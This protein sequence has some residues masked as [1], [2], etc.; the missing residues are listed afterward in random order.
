M[1]RFIKE[2]G[3]A[4][5]L[6]AAILLW[7]KTYAAYV[8]E[9]NLGITNTVQQI[10]LFVNPISSS[11]FFL[12]LGLLFKKKIQQTAII[13]I[14][15]LMSFLL[16]ANVVYYRFFSDF[17]TLPTI[18]QAK[19][20]GGQLGDSIFSLMHPLDVLYFIDTFILIGLAVFYNRP[21]ETTT[22]RPFKI[23][24]GTSIL[25]F[26]VN[27]AVAEID[28][29]ELL[30]RSFDRNYL[31]K[32]LGTYNFTIYD[33]VQNIK[34]NSQRA[35]ASSSD[36]TEVENY[37]KANHDKPNAEYFGKA[38]GMNVVYISLESLQTFAI[39]YKID[40]KEVTPFLNSLAHDNETF[41]FDNFFH[42]TGQGKTSDAEFMMDNS[43][44][45]LSQGSVF[46]NKAQNTLQSAPAILKSQGYTSA[47]FHGNYKTFWNRNEMYKAIGYDKFFDATY[48]DMSED[49]TKNYGLKDKPFFEESM[50]LLKSLKQP[51]YTKF[52]TLSNHFPFEMDEG[53]TDFPA[54]DT[55][56]SVVD[57][58]F[59]SANYMDQA[60]EQ[61]FND[62]KKAGLYDNTIVVMYGDHY[63]IS[64][65]H[66][67]AMA[68]VLGKDITPY[69][70]AQLQKVPLFIHAPGVKGIKSNKYGGEVDVAPT[71]LHLMGVNTKDYLMSGSD[72]LSPEHREIIPFRNGD[73]VSPEYTKTNGNYYDTKTGELLNEKD[74][75]PNIEESVKKELEMS[76]KIVDGDLLRFYKPKG[77]KA[78]NPSD[79]DYTNHNPKTSESDAAQTT[80]SDSGQ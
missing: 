21:S 64:E 72:L 59:Q 42:Q 40:G 73:F 38:K 49:K 26:L 47:A 25:V 12:G 46:I 11:L 16:Y 57:H 41:Y 70:N 33:A 52:I 69:E 55:G 13:V 45:P 67:K 76:D 71:L 5:F 63:G 68:K 14:H 53:D 6:I 74:I 20:N 29:P 1:K 77:F 66:N 17:I 54:G 79:Y 30:T 58:Y 9:F 60:I 28:R 56:D 4:F 39:D 50:P 51:F 80:K 48:Y 2:R 35:L 37:I 34:S 43:L 3:L 10:L 36:V 65:N 61:F 75:D 32:Y 7:L 31:V 19:T 44:Y 15:F 24:M 18:M 78:I 23:V 62:L 22:K 8:I 27:L